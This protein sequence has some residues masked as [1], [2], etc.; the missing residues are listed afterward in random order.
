M[1]DWTKE[2][3][4][5]L[6]PLNLRPEREREIA[7]E[8]ATHLEDRYCDALGQGAAEHTAHATALAEL[9]DVLV[10]ELRRVE[11]VWRTAEPLGAQHRGGRFDLL[12]H[13]LRYAVRSL[14]SSPGFTAVSLLTL[15]IGI[16]A[17]TLIL[18]AVNAVLV[19]PLPYSHPERLV[20]FWGTAPEKGL[21]EVAFPTGLAALFHERA[22]TLES[23][24]AYTGGYGFNLTGKGDAEHI[25]GALV[26]TD[27]FHVL[28]VSPAVGRVP[29]ASE[30]DQD[31]AARVVVLSHSLWMRHFGGDSSLVGH[32]IDLS[33]APATVVGVMPAGFDFPDRSDAWIPL[34]LDPS[35]FRCWCYAA[36]GRMR[37]GVR[38]NDVRRDI[39]TV[40]D[41]FAV[42]RQDIFPGAKPGGSHVIA[43]T[44]TQ[45]LVGSVERQLLILLA[46]V[47]CV[48]LIACANI[49]NLLLARTARRAREL[50]V[51]C[52]LGASPSRIATQ[53]LT[54]SM[55]LSLGGA[56]V[57]AVLAAWGTSALRQL[58]TK[59]F[60][61]IDQVRVDPIVLAATISVALIAGAVCGLLPAW[62]ATHVDLQDAIKNGTKGSDARSSRRTSNGFVVAQ[63]ALSLVLLVGAGL[64]L[65][66]YERLSRVSTG[67]RMDDVLTARVGVP[68]PRYDSAR[69]VRV[70][71]DR[72]VSDV[73]ALPGVRAVGIASDIPLSG[74]NT[75]D[76]I[77]AEGKEP[78]S[79]NEPVRVAT[80]RLVSPG[81]FDAIGTPLL[82]GR[83]ILPSDDERAPHVA[84][85]DELFAKHFWPGE[86]PIGK[87][88]Y[89]GGDTASTRLV[90]VVGVVANV[91]HLRLDEEGDLQVYQPFAQFVNWYSYLVV[92]T[93]ADRAGLVSEIRRSMKRIDPGV[94][95][96]DVRT[97]RNA[98]DESLGTR[99]LTNL[100]LA[101]FSLTA[102]IL[103]AIG[104]YGVM[105][106]GVNGRLREFGIRLALGARP[107]TVLSLVMRQASWLALGGLLIGLAGAI[108]T[109]RYLRA[110]LFGV[111]TLDWLTF[112]V[113]AALLTITAL[114]A[115]Y[116]PARRATRADPLWALKSE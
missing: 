54:E 69:T 37:P 60:P 57:G 110:L 111:G 108:A 11:H 99:R 25:E 72:L 94:P 19:R 30:A 109:T 73:R 23:F 5:A 86:D 33:G 8:L 88:F 82:R 90:T 98:V 116:L 35:S 18:S 96:F 28:G 75:Q 104:I 100:L 50:A 29:L 16:G 2:I 115:S 39:E 13:D 68:W 85:V 17:C 20:T 36:I 77:I 95:L 63:F 87:R 93:S 102:L 62:R 52:C 26:S 65:R 31:G 97:M 76:N 70:F 38:P 4:R 58:P 114:V 55:L 49:A 84:V 42:A 107:A 46:A 21:P 3:A 101:G 83:F 112:A 12:T 66:S 81:Y 67:Y 64:L 34:H 51:R 41:V 9:S 22:H 6:E 56:A 48:L 14:R 92:R 47:G 91:K 78:R 59:Q 71:Y 113:V 44:L 10:P 89:H 32:Q 105:S 40:T 43:M 74:G 15:A 80:I 1:P 27:F 79:P 7:D 61:R 53:L 24:A 106:L 103:A 45:R